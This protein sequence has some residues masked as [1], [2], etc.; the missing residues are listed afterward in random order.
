MKNI[1]AARA[2]RV[3]NNLRLMSG[4]SRMARMVRPCKYASVRHAEVVRTGK[5]CP[6]RYLRSAT[7]K[8]T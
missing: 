6:A 5:S 7:Q 4:I 1:E 3:G 8:A 2:G